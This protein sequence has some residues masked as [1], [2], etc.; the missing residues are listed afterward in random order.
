M[1]FEA[2]PNFKLLRIFIELRSLANSIM[3][4]KLSKLYPHEFSEFS[5]VVLMQQLLSKEN[6]FCGPD[7]FR[8]EHTNS[9][10]T[11]LKAKLN[12]KINVEGL[13]LFINEILVNSFNDTSFLNMEDS[14]RNEFSFDNDERPVVDMTHPVHF[15]SNS[16]YE[17]VN[18]NG[19]SDS[20]QTISTLNL[21]RY[22]DDSSNRKNGAKGQG[23]AE[24]YQLSSKYVTIAKLFFTNVKQNYIHCHMLDK[25]AGDFRTLEEYMR[26]VS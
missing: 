6:R 21:L 22:G 5:D 8:S 7:L 18:C 4:P 13:E 9:S 2:T 20:H 16:N 15:L 14:I 12:K 10:F 1:D 17:N 24:K 23:F 25:M 19:L 3:L 26:E 11:G